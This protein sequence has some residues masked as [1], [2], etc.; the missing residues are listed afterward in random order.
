MVEWQSA[1][2]AI[3]TVEQEFLSLINSG[4]DFQCIEDILIG[5]NLLHNRRNIQCLGLLP[6]CANIFNYM[7]KFYWI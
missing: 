6:T 4:K 1:L 2:V 7:P 3:A 5:L